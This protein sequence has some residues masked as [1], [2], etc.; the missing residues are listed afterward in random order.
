MSGFIRD[1]CKRPTKAFIHSKQFQTRM[2]MSSDI[3]LARSDTHGFGHKKLVILAWQIE[4]YVSWAIL[5][6][7]CRRFVRWC[8][9]H[10]TGCSTRTWVS[11]YRQNKTPFL[12]DVYVS[13]LSVLKNELCT[14]RQSPNELSRET[15]HRANQRK[16]HKLGRET[17]QKWT[18]NKVN[19][20]ILNLTGKSFYK[21]EW[22]YSLSSRAIGVPINRS[23]CSE[24]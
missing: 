11:Q 15:T 14:Q 10:C 20:R 3:P 19:L 6:E 24:Q 16:V 21:S 2:G 7:T 5:R 22:V 9:G 1:C 17:S 23:F 8:G 18:I 12:N 13:L 4:I